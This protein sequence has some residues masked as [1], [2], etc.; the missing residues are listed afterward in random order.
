MTDMDEARF[1][2]LVAG[3]A[4]TVVRRFVDFD[5]AEHAV[6]ERWKFLSYRF[7]PYCDGLSLFVV[8]EEAPQ[9]IRLEWTE[10]GQGPVIDALESYVQRAN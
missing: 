3:E 1:K 6:G 4:Y 2:H 7:V 9:R 8:R 5:G 10:A